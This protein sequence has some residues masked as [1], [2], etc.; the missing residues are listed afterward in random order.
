MLYTRFGGVQIEST[1]LDV[2]VYLLGG[3]EERIL[4]ILATVCERSH[5][6]LVYIEEISCVPDLPHGAR[7]HKQQAIL[8]GKPLGLLVRHFARTLQ[9]GFVAN[10]K[11]HSVRVGQ[12]ACVR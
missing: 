11:Y 1:V 5:A 6:Q 3:I 8:V 9:I 7:L 12:I 10:Q 4:D 2:L